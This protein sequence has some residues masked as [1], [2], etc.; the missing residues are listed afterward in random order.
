MKDMPTARVTQRLVL[1]QALYGLGS[2][3]SIGLPYMRRAHGWERL[4][5]AERYLFVANHVSLLD[6]ILLGG[7]V[8]RRGCY[9]ILVLGDKNVWHASLIKRLLS[10]PIAY[11]LDRGKL[12]RDRIRELQSF[13][14]AGNEFHLVVFPEGTR[15]D[16]INVGECQAGVYFIAQQARLPIVPIFFEN[17]HLVSTKSGGFHPFS[18]LRK[19]EVHFGEPIAPSAYL[20]LPRE[21]FTAFVRQN[22]AAL[23][24][25]Q[26]AAHLNLVPP[27]A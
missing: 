2:Y 6:S 11:L 1:V 24:P 8:W 4:D 13:G 22:I 23:R 27:L 25:T 3:L 10:G 21:E 9:P 15:G 7:L 5:S 17:M 19:V 16:G 14:R 18:G 26:S 20:D 12:N